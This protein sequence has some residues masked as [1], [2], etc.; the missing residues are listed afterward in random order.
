MPKRSKK[1]EKFFGPYRT[2]SQCEGCACS[3]KEN[4][5]KMFKEINRRL[6]RHGGGIYHIGRI[7]LDAMQW[8]FQELP[9]FASYKHKCGIGYIWDHDDGYVGRIWT[10]DKK[11]KKEKDAVSGA[12]TI[13]ATEA[14]F[15]YPDP[16]IHDFGP[17]VSV[18]CIAKRLEQEAE[19][20]KRKIDIQRT[21]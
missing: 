15:K 20:A 6:V 8:V 1:F 3:S 7:E 10:G 18:E 17:C 9:F 2:K 4:L 16:E 11:G 12:V 21:A 5:S 19:K 14:K 13:L